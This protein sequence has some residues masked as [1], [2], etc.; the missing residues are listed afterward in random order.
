MSKYTYKLYMYRILLHY[1]QPKLVV[2][3]PN[4]L[5]LPC[6]PQ[7]RE[8]KKYILQKKEAK[9]IHFDFMY[10]YITEP[11]R[12]CLFTLALDEF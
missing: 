6:L 4:F 11:L 9:K 3:L 8:K 5:D 12:L 1:A 2:C 7:T 10:L